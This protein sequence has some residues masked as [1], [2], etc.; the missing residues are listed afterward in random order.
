[1]MTI[2][3]FAAL[4][5]CNAQ[6]LRYY[7]RI[8]LLCPARVDEWTGYRYYE[9]RQAVD[10]VKIKNLQLAEFTIEEIKDLLQKSD[11]EVYA[12]FDEKIAVQREKLGRILEIQK[13]YLKEKTMMEKMVEKLSDFL[14]SVMDDKTMLAEFGL[15]PEE[16]AQVVSEIRSYLTLWANQSAIDEENLLLTVNEEVF[17][18]P[19]SIMEKLDSMKRENLAENNVDNMGLVDRAFMENQG[20]SATET[21]VWERHGWEHVHE[22]IDELPKVEDGREYSYL[23]HL[24][25]NLYSDNV[26]FPMYMLGT[27]LH[28]RKAKNVALNCDAERSTDGLNHFWLKVRDKD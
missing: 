4:C 22:F 18:G 11:E 9:D 12:A 14:F 10:F 17:S 21:V 25:E 2:K 28:R 3:D 24:N 20:N 19:E 15:G 6:T 13:T 23:F 7:D 8:G 5:G 26:S 16:G 27:V 1:M